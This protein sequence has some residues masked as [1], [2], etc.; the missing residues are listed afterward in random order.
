MEDKVIVGGLEAAPAISISL[1]AVDASE[2]MRAMQ[3]GDSDSQ[4]EA[5]F[6]WEE[7]DGDGGGG[8]EAGGLQEPSQPYQHAG[9]ALACRR[10]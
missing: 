7:A 2:L 9:A 3:G 6:D 1:P 5:D 10:S 8:G 4:G